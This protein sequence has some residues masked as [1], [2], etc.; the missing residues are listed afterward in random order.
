MAALAACS[1][2]AI[3]TASFAQTGTQSPR[4]N[5]VAG[6]PQFAGAAIARWEQLQ[7][8]ATYTFST[9]AGF[10]LKYPDFPRMEIIRSKAESRL[11]EEAP[12]QAEILAFFDANPPLTN[13][14]RARYALSLA[15]AQR[16]DAFEVAREAWRGGEMSGPTEAYLTGLYGSRF[17]PE[18]HAARV[19]ALL[20]QSDAEAVERNLI[21]LAPGERDLALARLALVRG[22]SPS[23]AGL[24]TP[25]GA[26]NDA[27]YVYNLA[28][29]HLKRGDRSAAI[30]LLKNRPQLASPAFDA[31]GLV[32]VMLTSAEA[33]SVSDTV[34]IASKV[35]DLF[36]PETDISKGSFRLRDRYT[37]LMWKGGHECPLAPWRWRNRCAYV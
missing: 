24:A 26:M 7:G 3:S 8:D 10:A 31:E 35:D 20:W 17:T 37:D 21:N 12:S 19:D 11:D 9:Y 16:G 25:A 30:N 6:Q 22:S 29:Y 32:G 18:D 34:R 15:A 27:G 1:L 28:S 5:M 4:G 14:G 36:A 13:A 33:A 23:A 2:G